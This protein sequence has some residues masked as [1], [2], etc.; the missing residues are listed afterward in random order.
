MQLDSWAVARLRELDDKGKGQMPP[1]TKAKE[2]QK[3]AGPASERVELAGAD[4]QHPYV[5]IDLAARTLTVGEP[6]INIYG[7]WTS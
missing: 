7:N 5:E 4:K 6:T 3:G 1:D 2:E